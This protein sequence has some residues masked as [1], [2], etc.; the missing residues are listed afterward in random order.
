MFSLQIWIGLSAIG[1][2]VLF[3]ANNPRA[4]GSRFR[5]VDGLYVEPILLYL[6][7]QGI[8][9]F[10]EHFSFS[11]N[12]LPLHVAMY[13]HSTSIY[14]WKEAMNFPCAFAV[15]FI[16]LTVILHILFT[17]ATRIGHVNNGRRNI[18]KAWSSKWSRR[19]AYWLQERVSRAVYLSFARRSKAAHLLRTCM[20]LGL[21]RDHNSLSSCQAVMRYSELFLKLSALL[22]CLLRTCMGLELCRDH[23]LLSTC[24]AVMRYSEVFLKLSALL[25][26]LL[27]TCMGLVL[28]RDHNL[29]S[30]CQPVMPD[31][32]YHALN[33]EYGNLTAFRSPI[34]GNQQSEA[35]QWTDFGPQYSSD[36]S[37]DGPVTHV[38]SNVG[39]TIQTVQLQQPSVSPATDALPHKDIVDI[40]EFD[41][42]NNNSILPNW[43]RYDP[44]REGPKRYYCIVCECEVSVKQSLIHVD[45]KRHTSNLHTKGHLCHESITRLTTLL[46]STYDR[47]LRMLTITNISTIS[48]VIHL[49]HDADDSFIS[50]ASFIADARI[51]CLSL[52]TA[53]ICINIDRTVFQQTDMLKNCQPLKELFEGST[54]VMGGDVWE[55]ALV[56]YHTYSIKLNAYVDVEDFGRDDAGVELPLL[57]SDLHQ[58]VSLRAI[59]SYNANHAS[60]AK[61]L[62]IKNIPNS[63]VSHISRLNVDMYAKYREAKKTEISVSSVCKFNDAG[64]I[65]RIISHDY[66]S[67]V[68]LNSL[69][70]IYF[71]DDVVIGLC[72]DWDCSKTGKQA[73]VILQTP[74]PRRSYDKITL[75]R[76]KES[77]MQRVLLRHL[78]TSLSSSNFKPTTYLNHCYSFK[79]LSMKEEHNL[80]FKKKVP[81]CSHLN[82]FQQCALY[83]SLNPLS[84]I[85]GPPG[86]GKT[87][88]LAAI[89]Q[90]AVQNNE[91]VLC[92]AWTNVAVRNLCE[93]LK[94]VL[95]RGVVSIKTSTEYKCWHQAECK[96]L[97]SVEAKGCEVQVLCMT[98]AN[99]LNYIR[100]NDSCNK[101]GP[102]LM[103]N[104]DLI[105]LDEASQIWEMDAIMLLH[106]LTGYKRFVCAGDHKQLSPYVSREVEDG[107]SIMNWLLRLNVRDNYFIPNIQLRRQYRM[108]PSVGSVVSTLFYNSNL[109]HH[110]KKDG[111][112]HLFFHC[113]KGKMEI[114]S[115]DR[116]CVDDTHRCARIY[117]N[118]Q[119]NSPHLRCH[120]L[121]YYQ[122]Q[123]RNVKDL[124][125]HISVCCVDS[126]QGQQVDVIILLL[127]LR[128]SKLTK[129]ILNCGRL[130]VAISRAKLDL[131]I[132][133]HYPTMIKNKMWEHILKSSKKIY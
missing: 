22:P 114:N 48:D 108:M 60:Q 96:T 35:P 105:V 120:V 31:V 23:N 70:K 68:R 106:G 26:C 75:N 52:V 85:H 124:Y 90:H 55:L 13:R 5:S 112:K 49:L 3:C 50:V 123:C 98:I 110:K 77:F 64:T 101:W 125:P 61:E 47:D 130:C 41:P 74:I 97:E 33:P 78:V 95:Q 126:F 87:R 1:F 10:T 15:D 19:R 27:R 37:G 45:G 86:T 56:L 17:F 103:I 99:Y 72:Q 20:G 62:S 51:M 16:S 38:Q 46:R 100:T 84:L 92:L 7:V 44:D 115:T 9:E 21:C 43:M 89:C 42:N 131:H 8:Y 73:D 66:N 25:P 14:I 133:G 83:T 2:Y 113:M 58:H 39:E 59:D 65:A 67:R 80:V 69:L 118:Y 54:R 12:S 121:T 119:K 63:V 116:W 36:C 79:S 57:N 127:T 40:P 76:C 81:K 82:E 91:G 24:Q 29:L 128:K 111:K 122:A 88:T 102:Q 6:A 11:I 104:R 32:Y 132:V 107:P 117:K 30:S 93:L 34:D 109:Q 53:T 94:K 18:R 129:F 71:G 28:C 4:P